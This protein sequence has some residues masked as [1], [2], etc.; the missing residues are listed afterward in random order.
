MLT[1]DPGTPGKNH[2]EVNTS[3]NFHFSTQSH[4]QIPATEIVY[5]IGNY[6]QVS[7]QLPLPDVELN[8]SHFTTFTQPQMGFKCKLLDEQKQ[9]VSFSIYPQII[10]PIQKEQDIQVFLPLEFEKSFNNFRVGEEIGYFIL[11]PNIIFNGTIVGYHFKNDLELMSEFTFSKII[12]QA[13]STTGLLNF[14]CRK[15]LNNHL[16]CMTSMGTEII[17]PNNEEKQYLFGLVGVQLLLGE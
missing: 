16:V 2:W 1:T 12:S 8:K 15:Q 13:Q 9:S 6:Y 7:V 17:T 3:L 10:L 14:G 5:G 4:I 11:S